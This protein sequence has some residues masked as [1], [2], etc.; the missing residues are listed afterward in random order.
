MKSVKPRVII[1]RDAIYNLCVRQQYYTCG[2]CESYD[3]MLGYVDSL[4]DIQLDT[5]ADAV[6]IIANDIY[7][8]SDIESFQS[9]YGCSKEEVLQAI[10]FEVG[11]CVEF[12]LEEVRIY[13]EM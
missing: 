8:H 7:D 5:V 1:H 12:H 9:E 13:E 3:R 10:Y 4:N 2:D 6:Y 11:K